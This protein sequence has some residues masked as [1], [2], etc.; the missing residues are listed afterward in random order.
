M[1][2]STLTHCPCFVSSPF[3]SSMQY[4]CSSRRCRP[5]FLRLLTI[6]LNVVVAV[7]IAMT[8]KGNYFWLLCSSIQPFS[9]P[10]RARPSPHQRR[11]SGSCSPLVRVDCLLKSIGRL[12]KWLEVGAGHGVMA[13]H[14]P[15]P[16]CKGQRRRDTLCV[17]LLLGIRISPPRSFAEQDWVEEVHGGND[18]QGGRGDPA[19][20]LQSVSVQGSFGAVGAQGLAT[21]LMEA[22]RGQWMCRNVQV[23]GAT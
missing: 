11:I 21:K 13:P 10:A 12:D 15:C 3:F 19:S 8:V 6:I 5:A 2:R 9:H 22:T 14:G 20:A 4:I 17:S 18:I 16:V 7:V 1:P 23:H